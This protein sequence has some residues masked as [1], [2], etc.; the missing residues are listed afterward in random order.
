M[1][2]SY[3]IK[4]VFRNGVAEPLEEV[5]DD[6]N[7]QSVVITFVNSERSVADTSR[8][9]A[10]WDQLTTLVDSCQMDTGISDLAHQHDHYLHNKPKRQD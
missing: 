6:R 7:G 1:T 9:D 3:S 8:D 10:A 5:E 2:A 4:G